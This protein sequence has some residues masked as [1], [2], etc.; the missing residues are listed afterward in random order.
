MGT[1]RF[2]EVGKDE[3]EFFWVGNLGFYIYLIKRAF[4]CRNKGSEGGEK[5][6]I[7]EQGFRQFPF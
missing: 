3:E 6:L 7:S 5:R 1:E 4:A 2:K